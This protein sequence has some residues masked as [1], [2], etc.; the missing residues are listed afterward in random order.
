MAIAGLFPLLSWGQANLV[1]NPSFEDPDPC[2]GNGQVGWTADWIVPVSG[3]TPDYYNSCSTI[4][5]NGHSTPYNG[6]GF[7]YA[8]SGSAYIGLYTF[9]VPE[10]EVRE[11]VSVELNSTLVAGEKYVFRMHYSL[12]DVM[13]YSTQTIG[14]KLTESPL[15]DS[16][17]IIAYEPTYYNPELVYDD[18]LNWRMFTDTI[19]AIGNE[20]YLT[21]A[22]FFPDS[23][24]DTV[25]LG[26]M[27]PIWDARNAYYYIDDVS[28]VP[29]DSLLSVDD[30]RRTESPSVYPNP[31]TDNATI[32][33]SGPQR[34]VDIHVFDV[35]GR[36]V[37]TETRLSEKRMQLDITALPSG[38]YVISLFDGEVRQTQK[39]LKQ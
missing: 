6:L 34:L 14:F 8:H 1:P 38:Q 36:T 5:G 9:L 7:Q 32:E 11:A 30:A 37:H 2:P 35:V 39:L 15:D 25:Y 4:A 24:S 16:I 10:P 18:S 33:L 26:P 29:L 12:A 3:N 13:E 23:L 27:D 22:N 21:I 20:R 17:P 31:A 19:T 28:L